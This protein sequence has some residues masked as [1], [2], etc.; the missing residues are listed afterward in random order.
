MRCVFKDMQ[1]FTQPL[2]AAFCTSSHLFGPDFRF[3]VLCLDSNTF[4]PSRRGWKEKKK[5]LTHSFSRH[6]GGLSGDP[7]RRD[8]D[9]VAGGGACRPD[10]LQRPD[11]LLLEDTQRRGAPCFP[12]RSW[13]YTHGVRHN[14][15]RMCF[16]K[17]KSVCM[18]VWTEWI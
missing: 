1:D 3:C 18:L 6:A 9:P 4:G 13:R 5:K 16:I 10:H 2:M 17:N 14:F 15:I 11:G 8:Q 12:E 7:S